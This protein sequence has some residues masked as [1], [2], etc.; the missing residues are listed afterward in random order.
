[1][2][3]LDR[4]QYFKGAFMVGD[5]HWASYDQ[6]RSPVASRSGERKPAAPADPRIAYLRRHTEML[7][8]I[9]AELD[10]LESKIKAAAEMVKRR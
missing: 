4:S 3:K 1:M 10:A 9:G 2:P 8:S 6:P 7:K 5:A